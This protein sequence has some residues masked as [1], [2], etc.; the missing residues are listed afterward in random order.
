MVILAS[1]GGILPIEAQNGRAHRRFLGVRLSLW[2]S[3][4]GKYSNAEEEMGQND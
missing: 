1:R 2:S 3:R 4:T